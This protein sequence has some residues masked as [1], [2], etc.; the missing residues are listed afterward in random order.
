VSIR[1]CALEDRDESTGGPL[2]Y[3]ENC[4]NATVRECNTTGGGLIYAASTSHLTVAD[5]TC[6]NSWGAAAGP[7]TILIVANDEPVLGLEISGNR[8]TG[9]RGGVNQ[10]AICIGYF[11]T[12]PPPPVLGDFRITNNYL[13]Y[14]RGL[15]SANSSSAIIGLYSERVGI[16]VVSGNVVR[17]GTGNALL[18]TGTGTSGITITGNSFTGNSGWPIRSVGTGHTDMII[19]NNIMTGNA[20]SG[21]NL[22]GTYYGTMNVPKYEAPLP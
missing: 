1:H 21:V 8:I 16:G 11:S 9:A 20:Q 10:A 7:I 12:L 6:A 14:C 22:V 2:V 15:D 5:S 17:A 18:I 4:L 3:L 19:A 13:T